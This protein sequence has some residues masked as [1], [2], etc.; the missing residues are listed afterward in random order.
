MRLHQSTPPWV[1]HLKM[2]SEAREA[3]EIYVWIMKL[4]FIAGISVQKPAA[5]IMT[6]VD[7]KGQCE[8]W[9]IEIEIGKINNH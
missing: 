5:V 8:P 6:L 1:G 9:K 4:I 2:L 7:F 3:L